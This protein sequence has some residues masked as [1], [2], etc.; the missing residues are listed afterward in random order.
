MVIDMLVSEMFAVLKKHRLLDLEGSG[1][2]PVHT[3]QPGLC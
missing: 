1:R 2:E 3:T